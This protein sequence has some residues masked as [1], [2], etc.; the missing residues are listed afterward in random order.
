MAKKNARK[1][2]DDTERVSRIRQ[3]LYQL[4]KEQDGF[5][6]ELAKPSQ[7]IIGS[8]YEV[9][10][11]CTKKNCCCQRGKRHGPFP[12]LFISIQGKRKLKMI[13]KQDRQGVEEKAKA[14][15]K[16]QFGLKVIR[17]INKEIEHLLE[18][19]KGYFLEE[20]Q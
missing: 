2:I 14:Y 8:F 13:R 18:E 7:M 15:R 20:Y 17:R 10:K 11:T 4:R 16:F 19:I 12:A 6:W 3:Q 9:Y 5:L 1:S